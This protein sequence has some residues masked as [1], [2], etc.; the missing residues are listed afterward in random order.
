MK[1]TFKL[2]VAAALAFSMIYGLA[3]AQGKGT[4]RGRGLAEDMF[5]EGGADGVRVSISTPQGGA[6]VPVSFSGPLSRGSQIKLDIQGNFEGYLYIVDV[7]PGEPRHV[8]FP[9]YPQAGTTFHASQLSE[10]MAQL[11]LGFGPSTLQVIL[12]RAAIPYLDAAVGR[13]NAL[14]VSPTTSA[15]S[16]GNGSAQYGLISENVE[17]VPPATTGSGAIP[18][19]VSLNSGK[20]N[21]PGSLLVVGG[22]A[23]KL[24]TGQAFVFE[25]HFQIVS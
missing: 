7:T 10:V 18:Q 16:S 19:R 4:G 23:G 20:P 2:L 14:G 5:N 1:P 22:P 21:N 15:G 12:S 25:L 13:I 17:I 6:Y 24:S 11:N 9:G 8:I 3:F